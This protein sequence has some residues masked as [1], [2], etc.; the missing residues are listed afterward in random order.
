MSAVYASG[1]W[2]V[3]E[4]SEDEFITRWKEFLGWTR[5][6]Q[7]ALFSANLI[8]DG[9]NPRHFL[10]FAEW[11]DADARSRWRQSPEFAR[12]FD[13]CRELCDDVYASDYEVTAAF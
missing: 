5:Q 13:A 1:N 7:P 8:R 6:T 10:S 4:G 2:N 11:G 3:K 9:Q 12:K